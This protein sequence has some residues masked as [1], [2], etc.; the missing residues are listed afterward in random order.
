LDINLFNDIVFIKPQFTRFISRT[1]TFEAFDK[2]C[3]DLRAPSSGITLFS[4][5]ARLCMRISKLV[6]E[7]SFLEQVR[8]SPLP[9]LSTV[10]DLYMVSGP[11]P[12]DWKDNTDYAQWLELLRL[13]SGVK[14]IYLSKDLAPCVVPALQDLVD[15]RTNQVFPALQ[16]IFLEELQESGPV[17][18]GFGKFVAARQVTSHPI[19]VSR[20]GRYRN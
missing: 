7:L 13:F 18:E 16:N 12:Q 19:T 6:W 3:V 8:T 1:P 4:S 20:W 17:Q 10:H 11:W 9:S 2:A 14:N 5:Y 15:G